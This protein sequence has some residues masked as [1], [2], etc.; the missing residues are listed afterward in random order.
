MKS[1]WL[2]L[3]LLIV[4]AFAQQPH[5][6]FVI[7]VG[8]PE[9]QLL[10]RIGQEIDDARKQMLMEDFL[11][12]YPMH[13]GA[14]WVC[15]TL[16]V[17]YNQQKEYDKSLA[18]AEKIYAIT[19]DMDVAYGALKAAEGKEDIDLVKK[20]AGR[21]S[22]SARKAVAAMKTPTT[23]D[24]KQQLT[25]DKDVDEYSEYALYVLALK[26]KEPKDTVDLIDA[27]ERQNPK[28]QYLPLAAPI[29]FE[30]L[31]KSGQ[32]A[33]ACPAAD[34]MAAG[35]PKNAEAMLFAAQCSWTGNRAAG[36]ISYGEKAA[37]ALNSRTKP[38]AGMSESD[39]ASKRQTMLGTADFYVGQ[40]Y[41]MQGRYGPANKSLRA[42]LG[43]I[44][45]NEQL[46][47][48]ALFDLGL[49]N[50]NLGK[51]IG[52]RA[53]MRQGL[54]YFQ[55]SAAMKSAVQDQAARNASLIR[56]ELGGR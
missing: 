25:Y 7:N 56:N 13:E 9:G 52:D 34:R 24:Q 50:Y 31:E 33:K 42:A 5:Q 2:A 39:W 53:Q 45:E 36:V 10:Q 54:K 49:A 28:S 32:G 29:Y 43:S 3:T 38:P 6:N 27:L 8:T 15:A 51:T 41:T 47:A 46:Y 37:A 16:E 22:A 1:S 26:L 20:W 35:D 12:K 21:T 30:A 14:P 18:V 44:K 17:A 19:P 4:P 23:D 40:G 48:I 55:E 11:N